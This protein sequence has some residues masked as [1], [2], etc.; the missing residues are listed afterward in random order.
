MRIGV[1]SDT[2]GDTLAWD[3]ALVAFAGCSLVVHCGDILYH[4][5]FNPMLPTYAPHQLAGA[6]NEAPFPIVFG[7]G[8]CDSEVDQLAISYPIE[9]PMAHVHLHDLSLLA[10]HGDKY[11]EE[12][13][14]KLGR[15]YGVDIIVRG[16]THECTIRKMGGGL[17]IMNPGS[18]SL[19]KEDPPTVA[20]IDTEAR[21]IE[22]TF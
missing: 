15:K 10:L 11:D 5:P 13:L 17:V 20:R 21:A 9:Q 1:I 8:N 12:G 2:H 19:P 16:H 3:R 7:K 18:A 4:G 22:K 14:E 6:L